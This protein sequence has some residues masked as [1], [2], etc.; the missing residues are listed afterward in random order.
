MVVSQADHAKGLVITIR[1]NRQIIGKMA[2]SRCTA[3]IPDKIDSSPPFS[4]FKQDVYKS[5]DGLCIDLIEHTRQI[6]KVPRCKD[7]VV[8]GKNAIQMV[9]RL[10]CSAGL[11]M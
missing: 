11:G 6:F 9:H 8:L 7:T 5:T 10:V 1:A 2:G 3:T 4:R